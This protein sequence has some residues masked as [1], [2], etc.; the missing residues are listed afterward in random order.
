[1]DVR[2]KYLPNSLPAED[3]VGRKER[4]MLEISIIEFYLLSDPAP[5]CFVQICF[6]LNIILT[7]ENPREKFSVFISIFK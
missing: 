6:S 1:M 7:T 2:R 5:L 3:E 4:T